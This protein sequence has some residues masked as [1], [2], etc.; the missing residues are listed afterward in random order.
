MNSNFSLKFQE[1]IGTLE[2]FY[3]RQHALS[4]TL[5]CY[6]RYSNLFEI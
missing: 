1:H 2:H 5:S 4:L 3:L 6:G